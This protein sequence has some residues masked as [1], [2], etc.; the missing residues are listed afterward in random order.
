MTDLVKIKHHFNKSVHDSCQALNAF[1]DVTLTGI[2]SCNK[3]SGDD[4]RILIE[5]CT[6]SPGFPNLD[7]TVVRANA[8]RCPCARLKLV[9]IPGKWNR[10][11]AVLLT[12][13]D[14]AGI[15]CLWKKRNKVRD[16]VA[17]PCLCMV[18]RTE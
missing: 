18:F 1:T 13:D 17:N 6:N 15:D 3:Q 11:V 4:S 2:F 5:F 12:A 7:S 16:I 9:E 10:T 14:I 8:E